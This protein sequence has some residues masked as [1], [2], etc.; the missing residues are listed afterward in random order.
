MSRRPRA[1]RR[2][3]SAVPEPGP[4]AQRVR[5]ARRA[6]PRRLISISS[7][8]TICSAL[9][10]VYGVLA[11]RRRARSR[12]PRPARRAARP[13]PRSARRS[14]TASAARPSSAA[15]VVER[16]RHR[17]V[18]GLD[19]EVAGR[20]DAE[21]LERRHV[22]EQVAEVVVEEIELAL[23]SAEP[24]LRGRVAVDRSGVAS[25]RPLSEQDRQRV[26]ARRPWRWRRCR[27]CRRT[28]R[29]ARLRRDA[30]ASTTSAT[31]DAGSARRSCAS[32]ADAR[33]SA[34]AATQ[35]PSVP[36]SQASPGPL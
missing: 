2:A 22:A 13:P 11:A 20:P 26:A 3:A 8:A 19:P 17:A 33:R 28:R 34:R 36:T 35:T 10:V 9:A 21:H 7:G 6:R 32:A 23:V 16:R 5:R 25:R 27:R 1:R 29:S 15:E 14:P 4:R 31:A 30:P 18:A 24:G 12:A